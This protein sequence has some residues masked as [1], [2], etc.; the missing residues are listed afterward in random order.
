MATIA[1]IFLGC[2]KCFRCSTQLICT[3][4]GEEETSREER[5]NLSQISQ[6]LNGEGGIQPLLFFKLLALTSLKNW[7]SRKMNVGMGSGRCKFQKDIPRNLSERKRMHFMGNFPLP[8]S[9]PPSLLPTLPPS[10]LSTLPSSLPSFLICWRFHSDRLI[11]TITNDPKLAKLRKDLRIKWHIISL[12]SIDG[13][14]SMEENKYI[15]I[16]TNNKHLAGFLLLDGL[17][18]AV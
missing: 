9:F 7:F 1:C 18:A 2:P 12:Q 16:K 6:P 4:A 8:P 10:L 11:M 15:A 14:H 17:N 5:S 13:Y 3:I